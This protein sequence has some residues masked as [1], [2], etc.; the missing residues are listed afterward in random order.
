MGAWFITGAPRG[1]GA[2]ITQEALTRINIQKHEIEK[3][4]A[5]APAFSSFHTVK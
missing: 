2:L 3:A 1:F 4:G 5:R